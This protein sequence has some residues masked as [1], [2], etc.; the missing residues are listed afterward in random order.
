MFSAQRH[1]SIAVDL[2]SMSKSDDL[3]LVQ[4]LFNLKQESGAGS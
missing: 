1:D 4:L 2:D 3:P